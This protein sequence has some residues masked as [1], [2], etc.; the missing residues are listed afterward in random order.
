M[1]IIYNFYKGFVHQ[2]VGSGRGTNSLQVPRGDCTCQN[3]NSSASF[4]FNN[5]ELILKDIRNATAN[6]ILKE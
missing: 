4:F 1:Q 5:E 3:S 6:T 2:C